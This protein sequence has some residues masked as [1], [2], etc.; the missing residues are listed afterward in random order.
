MAHFEPYRDRDAGGVRRQPFRDVLIR[1]AAL[2]D[3]TALSQIDASRQGGDPTTIVESIEK[4][5]RTACQTGQRLILVAERDA[6]VLGFGKVSYFNPPDDAPDNV[7][8]P[9]WYLSGVV[10]APEHRGRGIGRRLTRARLDWI[11]ERDEQA[12]SSPTSATA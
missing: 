4:A 1:P 5:I 10:V 7:A 2:Q 8:P 11:G 12:F 6:S 9:G 3:A